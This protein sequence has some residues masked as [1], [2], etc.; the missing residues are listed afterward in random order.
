MASDMC[1]GCVVRDKS[2]A[3]REIDIFSGTAWMV[4][5]LIGFLAP[6]FGPRGQAAAYG[7]GSASIPRVR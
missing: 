2:R 4:R 1:G 7:R 5:R 3:G 6:R